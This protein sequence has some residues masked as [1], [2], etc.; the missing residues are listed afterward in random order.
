MATIIKTRKGTHIITD[1]EYGEIKADVY[2]HDLEIKTLDEALNSF[3]IVIGKNISGSYHFT[4]PVEIIAITKTSLSTITISAFCILDH[5]DIDTLV[6]ESPC[7]IINSQINQVII[8]CPQAFILLKNNII[9]TLD[10][11]NIGVF[12]MSLHL[13]NN[14]LLNQIILKAFS[15]N[16]TN[17]TIYFNENMLHQKIYLDET[18]NPNFK[19]CITVYHNYYTNYDGKFIQTNHPELILYKD[20]YTY[21]NEKISYFDNELYAK[22]TGYH[23]KYLFNAPTTFKM[24]DYQQVRETIKLPDYQ[25]LNLQNIPQYVS[26][27]NDPALNVGCEATACAIVLSY[28]LKQKVTKN[29]LASHMEQ[30]KPNEKSF[31][32]AFIGD[33]YQDGW[34]CMSSVSVKAIQSFLNTNNLTEKYEVINLTNTPLY[35]LLKYLTLG[36]PIIVWAT[37]GNDQTMDHKKYGS[38]I[39]NVNGETLYWP[40]RDHSLVIAGYNRLT[41]EIFLADPEVN[42][43]SLRVRKIFEFENR[44][45]ELY[46][47]SIVI[48]P[49]S[50]Q[51]VKKHEK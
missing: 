39:F 4:K 13:E 15:S 24:L 16:D 2:V 37:M 35:E 31:W 47:Q 28:L 19:G 34:G 44:F 11:S 40:G 6:I 27:E 45:A 50:Q 38:T 25:K 18:F 9:K 29:H 42:N 48:I 46:S 8:N 26:Y 7:I 33:I 32:E 1:I 12:D 20:N 51:I 5:L 17:T 43:Q 22:Y 21:A 14:H 30:A 23:R 49:K 41:N 36:L 10:I 3:K